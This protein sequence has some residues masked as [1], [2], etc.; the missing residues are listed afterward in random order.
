[1]DH[2]RKI[3]FPAIRPASR[4]ACSWPSLGALG[5]FGVVLIVREH[6]RQDLTAPF[7][8][9]QLNNQ[10]RVRGRSGRRN[11]PV[12]HVVQWWS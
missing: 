7:F 6:Q 4:P 3:V 2:F 9:F 12:P 1:M 5:E 11:L 8:I 10:F